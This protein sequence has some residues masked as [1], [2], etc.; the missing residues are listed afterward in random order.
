LTASLADESPHRRQTAEGS[1][2]ARAEVQG[3][4]RRGSLTTEGEGP[5]R[6]HCGTLP[7]NIRPHLSGSVNMEHFQ[8]NINNKLERLMCVVINF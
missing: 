8:A 4:R 6:R 7:E 5:V 2:P 3:P 1:V